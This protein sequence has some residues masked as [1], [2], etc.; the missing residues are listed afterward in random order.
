[1]V[2]PPSRTFL[3]PPAPLALVDPKTGGVQNPKAGV[4]GS[5]DTATGAP[6]NHRGEAAEQEARNFVAGIATVSIS[7]VAGKNEPGDGDNDPVNSSIPDPTQVSSATADAQASAA[8]GVPSE[9]HDK[10]KQPMHDAMMEKVKPIMQGIETAADTWE[11][12]AKY[13]AFKI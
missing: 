9:K 1:M 4:L 13:G 6:E 8:G 3:F 11:R 5:H 12:F 7:S 10:T 2:Y